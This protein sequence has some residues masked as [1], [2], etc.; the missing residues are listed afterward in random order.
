MSAKK[1][2][3]EMIPGIDKLVQILASGL[4]GVAGAYVAPLKARKEGEARINT[5]EADAKVLLIRAEA[6]GKARELLVGGDSVVGGEIE[7]SNLVNE[8]IVYQEEKRL[9]NIGSVVSKA[10][11]EL[12]DT[13][14]PSMEP[15]HDWAA[16]FF[17]DVQ[18]VSSKEMQS[19]WGRVLAGE[20]ERPRSTSIRTLGILRDLDQAT[21]KLFTNFCSVCIFMLPQFG[22][23][24]L[25]GRVVSLEGNAGAN[26]LADFGLAFSELNRLNEHGLIISEYNSWRD[27]MI[28]VV[29][30]GNEHQRPI[31]SFHHEERE[32]ILVP[33]G[34]WAPD[35]GFKVHG[36]ALS[37]S[38]KELS[39]VV[40]RE[41]V[42]EYTAQLKEFFLKRKLRMVLVDEWTSRK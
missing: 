22:S 2:G 3:N 32:W 39:A 1:G 41:P 4:G 17:N 13:V 16:R 27:F 25:E 7:L 12:E 33:E 42:P 34:S 26:S 28:C 9:E 35:N 24:M 15:D 8:R 10:A 36:V 31:L 38:G 23:R 11:L 37:T 6:H 40:E 21:A 19:L 14:V 30:V 20:V 5:A 18:D 29:P